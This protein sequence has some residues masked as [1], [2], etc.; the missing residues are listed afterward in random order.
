MVVAS[1][2]LNVRASHHNKSPPRRPPACFEARLP[3]QSIFVPPHAKPSAD[4]APTIR[5]L[6]EDDLRSRRT[7]W[8]PSLPSHQTKSNKI[9]TNQVTKSHPPKNANGG[10]S[11]KPSAETQTPLSSKPNKPFPAPIFVAWIDRSITRRGT[12]PGFRLFPSRVGRSPR[13][14]SSWRQTPRHPSSRPSSLQQ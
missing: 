5:A 11:L 14:P 10:V 9:K 7:P 3:H 13:C 8:G 12:P 4:D 6:H 2:S 1:F